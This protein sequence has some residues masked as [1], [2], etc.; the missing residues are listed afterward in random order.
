MNT[1]PR[2][3]AAWKASLSG[4]PCSLRCKVWDS[5][6]LGPC[7][8]T[9]RTTTTNTVP[10]AR[11]RRRGGTGR[12]VGEELG[13]LGQEVVVALEQLRDLRDEERCRSSTTTK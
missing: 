11:R 7:I 10:G 3:G 8:A 2:L 6:V 9:H 1:A 5:H 13:E 12:G 4:L